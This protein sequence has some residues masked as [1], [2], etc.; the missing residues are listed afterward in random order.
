MNKIFL[1]MLLCCIAFSA[2]AQVK[3]NKNAKY[4]VEV[5][6]NCEMCKRRI[7]NAAF[8]VR[9][10]KSAEY[11]I[12]ENILHL[13]LDEN[14]CSVTDV[15]KAVAKAGHDT[16]DVKATDDDYAKLHGCCQYERKK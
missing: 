8:S 1:A 12:D 5:N 10:V 16:N 13:L 11:N 4:D 15:K 7:E 3:K 9:G 2:Q 6:G 14:K